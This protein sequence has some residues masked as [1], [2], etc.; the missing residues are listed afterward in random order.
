MQRSTWSSGEVDLPPPSELLRALRTC[1]FARK[2]WCKGAG[3]MTNQNETTNKT[4]KAK[5][6]SDR[7]FGAKTMSHGFTGVPNIL[8]RG[9]QRL[10]LSTTQFNILIQLLS[11]YYDRDKPPFPSK[12]QLAARL[13]ITPQTLRINIKALEDAGFLMREQRT[14]LAGDFGSNTYHLDGLIKKLAK[15]VPD[16]DKEKKERQAAQRKAETPNAQFAEL[17]TAGDEG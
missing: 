3:T 14:T 2:S 9:Q 4:K 6:S 8:L 12:K 13:S 7:I 15:L 17:Q 1:S 11:Y 16:F 10:G 5:S